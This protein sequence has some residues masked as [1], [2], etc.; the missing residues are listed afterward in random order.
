[1]EHVLGRPD[2]ILDLWPSPGERDAVFSE[3]RSGR[4][5]HN[6]EMLVMRPSGDR[7]LL[8]SAEDFELPTGHHALFVVL[9]ITERSA[10]EMQVHSLQKMEAIGTLAAGV[11]HDFNNLLTIIG[12]H[13]SLIL[14]VSQLTN[15][16][17]DA[18]EQVRT[19]VTR[20][21]KLT[22]QL[23]AYSRRQQLDVKPFQVNPMVLRLTGL[24]APVMGETIQVVHQLDPSVPAVVGDEHQIEQVV[25]NMAVNARD[26]MPRGGE[27]RLSTSVVDL[28]DRSPP[29]DSDALPGRYV[30]LTLEDTGAGM[31]AET[32]S[33]VFEPFFTTKEVGR[34]TGL[35]L[36]TAFGII[37]QH[38]GWIDVHSEPGRGTTFEVFLPATAATVSFS[39]PTLSPKRAAAGGECILVA[40]DEASVRQFVRSILLRHGYKVIEASNGPEALNLARN[41]DG[42]IQVLLTDFVM[43]EGMNGRELADVLLQERPALKVI[44][45]TGYSTELV[46]LGNTRNLTVLRKPF[47]AEELLAILHRVLSA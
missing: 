22:Q 6:R 1:L 44:V 34:G 36:A 15:E 31:D 16:D 2:S 3:I 46:G 11:A 23:L 12:G 18:L 8:L 19:A 29:R 5:V 17:R 37:K 7:R 26:A 35:G 9:D 4:T 10:L 40:E 27:L 42:Q 45:C 24:L 38:Q 33:R 30:R 13:V 14:D 21:A 47:E 41:H 43:P 20:A 25:I 28:T 39:P 32:L